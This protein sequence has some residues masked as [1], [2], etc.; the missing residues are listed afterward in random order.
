MSDPPT[1]ADWDPTRHVAIA[2]GLLTLLGAA[3]FA[4]SSYVP[5]TF[6]LRDGRFYTN[7]NA[8][9]T[10]SLAIEQPYARSW[11][12][13]DLGWNRN[14]DAGWS[15]IAVGRNGEHL[16]KHPLLLPVLS[17]PF[18]YALGLPG[19]LLFN[20]LTFVAIGACAFGVARRYVDEAD[21]AAAAIAAIALPL[22][23]SILN[24][25]YDYH[26]D[27][28]LLA[29]FLGGVLAIHRGRG[30]LAGVLLGLTVTLKPTCLMWVPSFLLL[31]TS[32][33]AALDKRGLLR[34][35][36]A[37]TVVLLGYA[38]LN[39]WLF[40]RPYWAGYNRTL[41]VVDGVP[42]IA[43]HVDA[44]SFPL[45]DG[46]R[47]VFLGHYGVARL[48][49]LFALALPGWAL[50]AR[51]AP[52]YVAASVLALG[53]AVLVFAKY[54]WEGDRFLWPALGLLVPALAA[55]LGSLLRPL[56][57][58]LTRL[59]ARAPSPQAP[60]HWARDAAL[61]AVAVTA[62]LVAHAA[63]SPTLVDRVA[64]T[65]SSV[66]AT[67]LATEGTLS[68]EGT[69]LAPQGHPVYDDHRSQVARTRGGTLVA[70]TSP[71]VSVLSAPF[72]RFGGEGLLP[73]HIALSALLAWLVVALA[74]RPPTV[75]AATVVAVVLLPGVRDA[76]LTGGPPLF[77]A[78][79]LVGALV[80][81]ARGCA[82]LSVALA[83]LCVAFAE[84]PVLAPVATLVLLA[85][86]L[87]A[88]WRALPSDDARR[89][90][91]LR[92]GLAS[93]A[94]PALL[95]LLGLLF[96]GRPLAVSSERVAVLG[97]EGVFAVAPTDTLTQR[98]DAVFGDGPSALR[99]AAPLFVLAVPGL[100]L[101]AVGRRDLAVALGVT[102]LSLLSPSVLSGQPAVPLF[103]LFLLAIPAAR[104]LGAL[105]A[106]GDMAAHRLVARVPARPGLALL[107]ALGTPLVALLL[108]GAARRALAS[109][110]F[111]VA[112][113]AAVQHAR[114]TLSRGARSAPVP[115]DFLA[116]EYQSWECASFE[117]GVTLTGLATA[118]P[119]HVGP[120]GEPALH[121]GT[122]Q[123]GRARTI[124][125][126]G[127]LLTDRLALTARLDPRS[128]RAGTLRVLADDEPLHAQ[129]LDTLGAPGELYPLDIDTSRL[130]GR[131]V[132]LALSVV[133]EQGPVSVWL[134]G[135]PR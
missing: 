42:G 44:F 53:C 58:A 40:G 120:D 101:A 41:V 93:A 57:D 132:T 34:A 20:L 50:L 23:T 112:D 18:F 83:C 21:E 61:A 88:R 29:L 96:W 63:T 35:V 33:Q 24:Y 117:R 100:A 135:G 46:L 22:G 56:R 72:A 55:S 115:C 38:L 71:L 39:T 8:T 98:L 107:I 124:Q 94:T 74:P 43:D 49:A 48:F 82:A 67:Q 89:T 116:W 68:V 119:E 69:A 45:E 16:P 7:V 76:L 28:L 125:Y 127:V 3:A 103:A 13:G 134:R 92:L 99:G 30:G 78:V 65:T 80:A 86:P 51:R 9:L 95:L 73:L 11:Y 52:R 37:G 128:G 4:W 122:D 108:V 91:A 81:A 54:D 114:V 36:G 19:L 113:P 118:T 110:V 60:P 5:H 62:V 105:G 90:W 102:L 27:T 2:L 64:R 111:D 133:S 1:R 87:R 6:I 131:R 121:L 84:A 17:A 25:A 12:G 77:T 79:A 75:L 85:A 109:D 106:L 26:V 70:R 59:S 10:E 47:R 31:A 97:L 15:N 104:V 130:A 66:A 129:A 32:P 123:R 14:L 126:D